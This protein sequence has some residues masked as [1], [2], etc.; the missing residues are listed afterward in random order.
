MDPD[1]A[2]QLTLKLAEREVAE[3]TMAKS[4]N[5]ELPAIDGDRDA[6]DNQ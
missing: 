2:R 6:K 4:E 1:K 3:K 5:S